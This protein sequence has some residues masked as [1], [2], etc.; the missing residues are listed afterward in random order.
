MGSLLAAVVSGVAGVA[1][2]VISAKTGAD[3][4]TKAADVQN[5]AALGSLALQ[6]E[7]LDFTKQQYEQGRADMA[8]WLSAGKNTLHQ[9]LI[10]TGQ[11]G[12][13]TRFTA[14]TDP[15]YAFR[16]SEGQK[17]V[18]NNLA[19]LGMKNSGSALKALTR[20]RMGVADQGFNSYLDRLAGISGA[21]QTASGNTATLGQQA[22]NAVNT[23]LNNMGTT[24]Q[25]GADARASGYIGSANAWQNAI[26]DTT[27]NLSNVLGRYSY[28]KMPTQT[29]AWG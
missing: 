14:Q 25:S 10:E 11:T 27:S 20:F 28:G 3:A 16:V 26:G 1:G 4:S 21:G 12:G 15:G 17:G 9:Y 19:A 18:I 6:K 24:M 29:P 7:G 8:P 2:S 5:T 22:S 23:G 13:K